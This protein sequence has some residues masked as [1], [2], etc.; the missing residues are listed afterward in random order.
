MTLYTR[1][2]KVGAT[3]Y[4]EERVNGIREKHCTGTNNKAEAKKVAEKHFAG[5]LLGQ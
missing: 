2:N 3:W 1:S 5:V 4:A